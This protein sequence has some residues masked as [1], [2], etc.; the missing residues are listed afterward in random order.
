RE[1]H[2]T[3][4]N[5]LEEEKA[6]GK[7]AHE[8]L[9][10]H[11]AQAEEWPKAA[12]YLKLAGSEAWDMY[13]T[14]TA[15]E[16]LNRSIDIILQDVPDMR[17]QLSDIYDKLGIVL[18][19]KGDYKES[20]AT[21]EKMLEYSQTSEDAVKAMISLADVTEIFGDYKRTLSIL[22]DA[23][24]RLD[25]ELQDDIMLRSKLYAIRCSLKRIRGD[26]AVAIA[27]GK[28]SLIIEKLLQNGDEHVK[29]LAIKSFNNLG[30]AYWNSGKLDT[31]LKY[32]YKCV[33]I[34]KDIDDKFLIST[35]YSNMGIIFQYKNDPDTAKEYYMR[36]LE[37]SLEIGHKRSISISYGNIGTLYYDE[38]KYAEAFEYFQKD[39]NLAS[40][41]GDRRGL[42]IAYGNLANIYDARGEYEE[43]IEYYLKYLSISEE[44]DF[45]MGISIAAGNIGGTYVKLGEIE[46]GKEHF[47]KSL[48][49]SI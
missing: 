23:E 6:K 10:Y 22:K 32:F 3:I 48:E 44:V 38:E 1:F 12:K 33:D 18:R 43:A 42:G 36:S 34:S 45:K 24:K 13:R 29:R 41:I 28:K 26:S 14:E 25:A 20:A 21:Y 30:L 4:G 47:Q 31:A 5:I 15:E 17:S 37:V 49:V 2:L 16:Y 35:I 11:Y 39:I 40:E 27:E 9:A 46:K 19:F 8:T 7:F